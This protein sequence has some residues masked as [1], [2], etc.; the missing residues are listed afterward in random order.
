M[1]GRQNKGGT[2]LQRSSDSYQ[3]SPACAGGIQMDESQRIHRSDCVT[4]TTRTGVQPLQWETF[5]VKT[6]PGLQ[7]QYRRLCG[8][9]AYNFLLSKGTN[10]VL[11]LDV[12]RLEGETFVSGLPRIYHRDLRDKVLFCGSNC[13]ISGWSYIERSAA[14]VLVELDARAD[15]GI[16]NIPPLYM[17][18]DGHLRSLM[19]QFKS[20]VIDEA[21]SLAGY[22]ESLSTL[23]RHHLRRLY[24][25]SIRLDQEHGGLTA[26]QLRIAISYIEDR[27]DRELSIAEMA[28]S[29]NMSPFHFIRMFKRS[30]GVPPHKFYTERRITRAQDLLQV[31]HLSI[32]EVAEMT[33]FSSASQFCRVFRKVAGVTPSDFRRDR[34]EGL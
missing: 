15:D 12:V 6:W 29:L 22:P 27:L 3:V 26:R 24:L 9:V 21:P 20:L 34:L 7:I 2:E 10:R 8:P 32:N 31:P 5:K 23:L 33:G 28:G 17:T 13:E 18:A 4:F 16:S 30:A 11:F 14:F 19:G 25:D 1:Q